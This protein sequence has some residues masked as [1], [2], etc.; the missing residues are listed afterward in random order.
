MDIGV[1]KNFKL[2]YKFEWESWTPLN[3]PKNR[4]LQCYK[5]PSKKNVLQWIP[6]V[7]AELKKSTIHTAFNFF[8]EGTLQAASSGN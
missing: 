4:K 3:E 1:N 2:N 7:W 6:K 5:S 8:R